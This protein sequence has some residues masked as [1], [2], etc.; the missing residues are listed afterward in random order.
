MDHRGLYRQKKE[1]YPV[2]CFRKRFT[3]EKPV[4]NARLYITACG[5]YEARL[6]G[7]RVGDYFRCAYGS[8]ALSYADAV[9]ELEHN[10][11]KH[12]DSIYI[13]GGGAKNA[14]LNDLTE[15]ATGKTVIALPIEAMAIGN[16][17]I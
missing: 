12:F 16:L 15:K 3:V 14:F 4:K 6:G 10:T 17:K 7:R 9:R 8:L 11:G 5:L 2:D 13:V 1:R